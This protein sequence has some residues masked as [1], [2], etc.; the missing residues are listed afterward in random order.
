MMGLLA[1]TTVNSTLQAVGSHGVSKGAKA[2]SPAWCGALSAFE[3]RS[4][5]SKV[6]YWRRGCLPHSN[7]RP[8]QPIL[9]PRHCG[10]EPAWMLAFADSP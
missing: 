1:P 9:F 5:G 3:A 7:C 2:K 6:L 10:W 4:A 8:Y